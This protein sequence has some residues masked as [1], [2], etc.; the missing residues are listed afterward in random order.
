[1]KK[2]VLM[3]VVT[4]SLTALAVGAVVGYCRAVDDLNALTEGLQD[5]TVDAPDECAV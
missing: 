2:T 3:A 4:A 1:M 5:V